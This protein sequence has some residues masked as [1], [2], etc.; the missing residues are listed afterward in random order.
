MSVEGSTAHTKK[1]GPVQSHF[2][3]SNS[4]QSRTTDR[5]EVNAY[6][7]CKYKHTFPMIKFSSYCSHIRWKYSVQQNMG[8]IVIPMINDIVFVPLMRG[9][10]C[11]DDHG[12]I[13]TL[14]F[15]GVT[16][17][18]SKCNP[19]NVTSCE[20]PVTNATLSNAIDQCWTQ[21]HGMSSVIWVRCDMND[22][23]MCACMI[24]IIYL[25]DN[26]YIIKK[27][28]KK[29]IIYNFKIY[30]NRKILL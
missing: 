5:F 27:S 26:E 21:C 19:F 10:E 22:C 12:M 25:F 1:S 4:R 24:N 20:T 3:A 6:T 16:Q 15:R 13:R 18:L 30:N 9:C 28:N 23:I 8:A 11:A 14:E 29:I 7:W 17:S 2:V